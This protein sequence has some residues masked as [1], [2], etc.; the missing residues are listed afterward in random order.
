M[1]I[2]INDFLSGDHSRVIIAAY[3]A[4]ASANTRGHFPTINAVARAPSTYFPSS[5]SPSGNNQN[6]T[7]GV[8]LSGQLGCGWYMSVPN[9]TPGKSK[10]F[11]GFSAFA[12]SPNSNLMSSVSDF[13][14]LVWVA[15]GFGSRT[16]SFSI[17]SIPFP[18][19]DESGLASG[20][21]YRVAT[22]SLGSAG[23][24]NSGAH[25]VYTNTENLNNRTGY[26]ALG[27]NYSLNSEYS[28][29]DFK[30]QPGDLGVKSIQTFNNL[31]STYT[32][33][34]I[35]VYRKLG[36]SPLPAGNT[37]LGDMNNIGLVKIY[38]GTCMAISWTEAA[39]A[40]SIYGPSLLKFVEI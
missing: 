13:M 15:T 4:E 17:N 7:G 33:S 40:L 31:T 37:V 19:R 9:P 5:A 35:I 25:I 26:L 3:G 16:G 18:Q 6:F 28:V 21:G 14:D 1:T 39:N 22:W 8:V 23:T 34:C 38:S 36:Q 29:I 11:Y 30:L 10:Y 32:N 20:Y 2:T 24:L 27:Q 12:A